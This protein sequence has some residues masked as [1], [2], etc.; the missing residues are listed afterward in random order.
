LPRL[1]GFLAITFPGGLGIPGVVE[2]PASHQQS[3]TMAIIYSGDGGWQV[4][5]CGLAQILTDHGIPVVGL[6]T[7]HCFW[8]RRKKQQIRPKTNRMTHNPCQ[9]KCGSAR[10]GGQ[11]VRKSG[12][13][14]VR[15]SP[16][17]NRLEVPCS[18]GDNEGS[19][20]RRLCESTVHRCSCISVGSFFVYSP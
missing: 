14:F 4:A 1:I 13:R 10:P 9:A 20:S 8:S 6:N 16:G 5:D 3:E 17:K 12:R 7:L 18:P 19:R 15:H 2:V 11:N